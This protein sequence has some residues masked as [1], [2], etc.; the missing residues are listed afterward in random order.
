MGAH[1]I[2]LSF[3]SFVTVTPLGYFLHSRFT[4]HARLSKYRF[5]RFSGGV[6]A[7]LPLYFVIMGTLCSGIG[8]SILWAAPITTITLYV[9]NYT[10]A[11]WAL[12][13]RLPFG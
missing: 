12:R 13:V 2:P 11:Y 7:G 5:L 6:A 8:L 10:L 1:Y 3:L 9:W 4:F